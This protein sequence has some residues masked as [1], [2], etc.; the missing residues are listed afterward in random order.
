MSQMA[1]S[2]SPATPHF[3][4][5]PLAPVAPAPVADCS[6]EQVAERRYS[7]DTGPA[8]PGSVGAAAARDPGRLPRLDAGA[9]DCRSRKHPGHWR[10]PSS[11]GELHLPSLRIQ[12]RRSGSRGGEEGGPRA[13]LKPSY[14]RHPV[15]DLAPLAGDAKQHR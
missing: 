14:H 10:H 11:P 7:G 12:A 1:V 8:A 2:K 5:I 6:P 13:E 3:E 9:G 15:A 4:G